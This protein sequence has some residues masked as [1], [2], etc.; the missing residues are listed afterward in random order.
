MLRRAALC[1]PG[2]VLLAQLSL[3]LCPSGAAHAQ[4][5][6]FTIEEAQFL[7]SDRRRPPPDTAPWTPLRLPDDWNV[8]RPGVAGTGWYR[9]TF[10]LPPGPPVPFTVLFKRINAH[11]L[12]AFV[13]DRVI[14][15]GGPRGAQVFRP[16]QQPERY[17]VAPA[18]LR[19][20]ENVVHVR[21]EADASLHQGLH[22]LIIGAAPQVMQRFRNLLNLQLFPLPMLSGAALLAGV[23]AFAFWVRE[24]GDSVL[25]WFAVTA[26]AWAAVTW[27]WF[28]VS[29]SDAAGNLLGAIAFLLRFSPIPPMLVLCLRLAGRPMI[30]SEACLWLFTAAGLAAAY[31]HGASLSG[32]LITWWTGV[33]LA[34]LVLL[35]LL[36]ASQRDRRNA[37]LWLLIA[38]A[39]A[40]ILLNAHD[41]GR[42][43]GWI[44]FDNPTLAHFHVPLVLFALGANLIGR[45]FDAIGRIERARIE[46]ESRVA[47]KAREIEATYARVRE[48]ERVEALASERQRIMT[49]MHDGVGGSLVGLLGAVQAGRTDAREIERRLNEVLQELRLAVDALEPVNGDLAAVLGGVRHRMWPAIEDSGVELQWRVGELPRLGYLTPSVILQIQRIVLEALSNALRHAGA[50]SVSVDTSIDAG[51]NALEIRIADDGSGFDGDSVT[52]GRGLRSMRAR[53]TGIG[54]K[55]EV[56]SSPAKGT[57]I[58]LRLP[59]TGE[60]LPFAA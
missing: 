25:L 46:L 13:N 1:I 19:T 58:S 33:Y 22:R 17:F 49:D 6:L 10:Q 23:L 30:K 11:H 3:A 9:M 14:S 7:L 47:A 24:R 60:A 5:L 28:T 52:M 43:I 35:L 2:F 40:A 12:V 57:A 26:L 42:W 41:Y 15:G 32:A 37:A 36:I 18:L 51:A 50:R 53:A 38:A 44:D 59:L 20:G 21:I 39:T 29:G 45:H 8:S 48:A 27:P 34:L 56:H 16:W 55:L 4:D 31:S 54:G